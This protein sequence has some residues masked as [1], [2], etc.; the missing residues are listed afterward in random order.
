MH[1]RGC[2]SGANYALLPWGFTV[3][4]S[5]NFCAGPTYESGPYWSVLTSS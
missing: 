3:G 1:A 2:G 4:G 5:G